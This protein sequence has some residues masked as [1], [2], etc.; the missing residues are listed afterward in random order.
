MA[1]LRRIANL[2]RRK[3]VNA[4]IDAELQ[5]HLDL[6]IDANLA[7]GMAPAEA[8]RLA[9]VQ[10]GNLTATRERVTGADAAL[11]LAGVWR[12]IRYAARQLRKSPGFSITVIATL[13]IGIGANVAVF[14]SMDAVVLRPLAVPD[15]DRVATLNE[16]QRQGGA[17][18]ASL[19]D[20]IDWS[21]DSHSFEDMAIRTNS[22][23]SLT[24]AGD[25]TQVHATLT[26]AGFFKVLKTQPFIGRLF[27]ESEFSPGR[28]GV[29]V[30][31][32]GFWKR[33]F[34]SDPSVMGKTIILDEREY[35]VVGVLPKPL[36]FPAGTDIFLPFAPTPGQ[37]ADRTNRDYVAIGRLR[38]GVTLGKAQSEI[39][40][41]A[42]RLAQTYPATNQ[43]WSVHF[44]TLL[45][46][47][48]GDLTP[49]YYKFIMGATFFVLLIVCANVANLQLA[50]GVTRRS[51]IAMRSALGASRRRILR[52][53]L[54]ENLL[55]ALLGA[56]GG[57]AFAAIYLHMIVVTMPAQVARLIPGWYNTSINGRALA[58]S[59]VLAVV[60]GMVSGLAPAA[61]AL[62]VRVVEQLRAGS[63]QSVG[64]RSRLRSVFAV[65]Q[66]ALAVALVIGAALMAKGMNA[67]LHQADIY[68]PNRILTL[69]FTLPVKRYDTP[70]KQAAWFRQSLERLRALPG[71]QHAEATSA[72]PYSDDGWIQDVEIENQSLALGQIHSA[73]RLSVSSGYFSAMHIALLEGRNLNG[74]DSLTSTPVAVV[75]R[76][77]VTY[78]FSGQNPIGHRIRMVGIKNK[79]PW[80]TV[81]GVVDEASYSLWDD[82]AR[83]V[84]Y[85]STAQFPPTEATFALFTNGDPLAMAVPVRK[86]L[87]SV[88]SGLPIDPVQ[89]YAK[90]V[91]DNMIGLVY[92]AVMLGIDALIALLLA[93]VGIFAIMSNLVGERTREIGV[94]LAMGAQR[95]DVMSLVLRRAVWLTAAGVSM[96]LIA[97]FVLAHLVAN[98]LR[99]VRS[100]DPVVFAIV[101][102]VITAAALGSSWIPAH[103]ASRI[104]PMEALRAD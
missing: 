27:N 89:T 71:V 23:M 22:D 15:L 52:Q 90:L 32:Y 36:Q 80:V 62:R 104:D 5:A 72:M 92:A 9:L 88:D 63:R 39:Q 17:R 53:L 40:I 18:G 66:I 91:R 45:N 16:Q 46:R 87:A 47:F 31:S 65:A 35:T 50:R 101:T 48:E 85:L 75:S 42:T 4:E 84:V 2:F 37:L 13:A 30:L 3:R 26:S 77:F 57:V 12:D 28:D 67:M 95:N 78:Y 34:D 24:G 94:R 73:T 70:E 38:D 8:R 81:V 51:E 68:A 59:L 19:A 83:P 79:E 76:R 25:A 58:F 49:L 64:G 14:S 41:I 82:T 97:A 29:A 33:R 99:G 21:R 10:F 102:V 74:S 60:A 54:T 7:K 20:F 61:D 103:R 11:G 43:G 100:D 6:R 1:A 44:E 86:V 96:G 56:A 69:G 93:A 98:L 55:L